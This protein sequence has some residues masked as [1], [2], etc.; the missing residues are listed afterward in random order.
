MAQSCVKALVLR[1]PR[2]FSNIK[3]MDEESVADICRI[4]PSIAPMIEPQHVKAVDTTR[5]KCDAPLISGVSPAGKPTGGL[6]RGHCG[7]PTP[8]RP[9]RV[10][11]IEALNQHRTRLTL[12]SDPRLCVCCGERKTRG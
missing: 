7:W 1:V 8:A 5:E 9:P 4:L 11:G 10:G 6:D 2:T 3:P 12:Y